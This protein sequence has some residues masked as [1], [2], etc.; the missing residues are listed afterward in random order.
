MLRRVPLEPGL[1]CF[2]ISPLA[3]G[4][5]VSEK[6]HVRRSSSEPGQLIVK[7]D[8]TNLEHFQIDRPASPQTLELRQ[9]FQKP[10][11]ELHRYNQG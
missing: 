3:Q 1:G 5:I 8:T 4:L 6:K 9:G 11:L 10:E 7:K 2:R